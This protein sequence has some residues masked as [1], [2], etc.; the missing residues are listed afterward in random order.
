MKFGLLF[1]IAPYGSRLCIT[2]VMNDYS[3]FLLALA[4]KKIIPPRQSK[5]T[6]VPMGEPHPKTKNMSSMFSPLIYF[7]AQLSPMEKH[8]FHCSAAGIA[9][10]RVK[11]K[12]CQGC[13]KFYFPPNTMM[14]F[15]L[16][17]INDS[18][19]K[20]SPVARITSYIARQL[21]G[22]SYQIDEN[23]KRKSKNL[24]TVGSGSL[25]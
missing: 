5:K 1:L 7:L 10:L 17:S 9:I 11:D 22:L 14:T 4:K 6:P 19:Y 8:Q 2:D 13:S 24:V 12:L 18:T 3:Y 16:L 23:E 21:P 20:V 15:S 25:D